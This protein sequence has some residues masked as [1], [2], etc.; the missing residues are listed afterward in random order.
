VTSQK[1]TRPVGITANF[2]Q[3]C[4][5]PGYDGNGRRPGFVQRQPFR[6]KTRSTLPENSPKVRHPSCRSILPIGL[7]TIN[8][9]IMNGQNWVNC[10]H[11]M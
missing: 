2:V 4:K 6:D 11:L 7:A 3:I 5:E 9:I 8:Q 1:S 10:M